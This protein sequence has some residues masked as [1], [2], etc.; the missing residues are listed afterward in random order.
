MII[1]WLDGFSPHYDVAMPCVLSLAFVG[2]II[3][4]EI[5]SEMTHL[6]DPRY[7]LFSTSLSHNSERDV[8][9]CSPQTDQ[10]QKR[11]I[12]R[13]GDEF[14]GRKPLEHPLDMFFS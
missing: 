2:T 12:P 10:Y 13:S 5:G 11:C 9:I 1:V 7:N 8:R 3:I 4:L 14:L 6:V